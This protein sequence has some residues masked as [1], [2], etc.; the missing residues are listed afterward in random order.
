MCC[1]YYCVTLRYN[2]INTLGYIVYVVIIIVLLHI[3]IIYPD[4]NVSCFSS[5][6][7]SLNHFTAQYNFSCS[8]CLIE[9]L[10]DILIWLPTLVDV[11]M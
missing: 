9:Y 4:D 7:V 10:V 8:V 5:F 2:Q 6:D 3:S 11:L 1:D